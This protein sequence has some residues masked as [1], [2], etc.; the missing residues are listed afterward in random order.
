MMGSAGISRTHH[1]LWS[2]DLHSAL[3]ARRPAA[4][5]SV[6]VLRAADC[7]GELDLGREAQDLA[8]ARDVGNLARLAGGLAGVPR[9]GLALPGRLQ[10][11]S[12]QLADGMAAPAAEIERALADAFLVG[13]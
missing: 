11:G 10:H 12:D 2:H 6:P 5:G 4:A 7:L 13:E 1:A 9:H 3:A 8:R